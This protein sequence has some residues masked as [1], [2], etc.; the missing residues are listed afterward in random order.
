MM[1]K[2]YTSPYSI[3]RRENYRQSWPYSKLLPRKIKEYTGKLN[4]FSYD[5]PQ[6]N[7]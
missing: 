5:I 4:I 3:A 2:L 7:I 1:A 6:T